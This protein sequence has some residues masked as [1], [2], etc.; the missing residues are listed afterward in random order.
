MSLGC[1]TVVTTSHDGLRTVEYN[2]LRPI[3][4][5]LLPFVRVLSEAYVDQAA[6]LLSRAR[7]GDENAFD[8]LV[9]RATPRLY[10]TVRRMSSDRMEA[11]AI[12][13][14]TW[15]RAWRALNRVETDQPIMPWLTTIAVNLA[16]DQWRQSR[17]LFIEAEPE[18]V[19]ETGVSRPAERQLLRQEDARQL[20]EYVSQLRPAYRAVIALRYDAGLSYE[21]IAKALSSPINTVRTHLR[22]AKQALRHRMEAENG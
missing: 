11:E 16:R 22:R 8:L 3:F 10:R 2:A 14:E 4:E 18:S 12:V 21:E 17:R 6:K 19:W 1:V 13:Q 9:E 20:A 5:T 7:A 15:L